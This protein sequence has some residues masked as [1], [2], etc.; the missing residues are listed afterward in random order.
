MIF[1]ELFGFRH[2]YDLNSRL[3]YKPPPPSLIVH[4]SERRKMSINLLNM[5][6]FFVIVLQSV[7]VSFLQPSKRNTD[8]SRPPDLSPA[9]GDLKAHNVTRM[10]TFIMI[11]MEWGGKRGMNA[12]LT[13]VIFVLI[14]CNQNFSNNLF[15]EFKSNRKLWRHISCPH[16]H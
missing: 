11:F 9:E 4:R 16:L 2:V 1:S 5:H 7:F 14:S 13:N 10:Y 8:L 12:I 6:L 15:L 3:G